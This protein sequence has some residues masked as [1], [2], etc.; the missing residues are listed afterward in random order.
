MDPVRY[1]VQDYPQNTGSVG[2]NPPGKAELG[3]NTY[4]AAGERENKNKK[5]RKKKKT[6]KVRIKYKLNREK[7][8]QDQKGKKA[9]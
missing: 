7:G 3:K 4:I 9:T 2:V 1:P 6:V 8:K 5:Q